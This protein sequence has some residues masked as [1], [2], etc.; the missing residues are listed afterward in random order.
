MR[1]SF[2]YVAGVGALWEGTFLSYAFLAKEER[3]WEPSGCHRQEP[4]Y[5]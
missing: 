4:Y 1:D 3:P 5:D 2:I